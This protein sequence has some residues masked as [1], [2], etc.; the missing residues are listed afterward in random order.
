MYKVMNNDS[1]YTL[2]FIGDY[3]NKDY[4]LVANV[5]LICASVML[6]PSDGLL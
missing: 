1:D 2:K 4:K 6:T 5:V 3:K